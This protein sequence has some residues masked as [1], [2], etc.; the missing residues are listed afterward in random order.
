M[1]GLEIPHTS[2]HARHFRGSV[3]VPMRRPHW[4]TEV[5]AARRQRIAGPDETETPSIWNPLAPIIYA[6]H[7]GLFTQKIKE[8]KGEA[9]LKEPGMRFGQNSFNQ[10]ERLLL[11]AGLPADVATWGAAQVIFET[12]NFKSRVSKEDLNLSGIKWINQPFQKATRGRKANDGGYYA[13]FASYNDWAADF[14][15]I[16]QYGGNAAPIYATNLRDYVNR[17][18]AR[19][20]FTSNPQIYY[21]GLLGILNLHDQANAGQKKERQEAR[22]NYPDKKKGWPWWGY[23][24]AGVGGLIILKKVMD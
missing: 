12:G 5:Y 14:K 24:L 9:L 1:S 6:T 7:P 22:K 17:L 11:N 4:A 21:N 19:H 18:Y 8:V 13:H 2:V 3:P 20:Y 10:V 15:R 23:A 16:L